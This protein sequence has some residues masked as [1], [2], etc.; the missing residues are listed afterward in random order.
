MKKLSASSIGTFDKCP[1]KYHYQYIEK[2]DIPKQDWSHLELGKCAH[3][4]LE[5]FHEDLIKNVRETSDYPKVMKDSFKKAVSEF[6]MAILKDSLQ[7]LKD[8][9]Q[10]YLIKIQLNGLPN[11]IYNELEFSFNIND[12][13]VRGFIDRIDKISDT[14]FKVVDYKTNKAPKY[15]TNFQLQL[16]ALAIKDKFPHVTKI[17]GSYVLLKHESSTLDYDFTDEDLLKTYNKVVAVGKSI[18][19]RVTWDKNPSLLCNWCDFQKL[20][21]GSWI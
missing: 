14:E 11:V 5:L 9:I 1:K 21:Q 20:C 15:L 6:D 8:I 17:S 18:D 12:Y 16:Y 10:N 19:T 3:R 7:D 13:V 2:P 4:T